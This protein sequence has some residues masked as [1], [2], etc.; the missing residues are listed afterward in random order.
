MELKKLEKLKKDLASASKEKNDALKRITI[1][2]VITET[3]AS[4]D[5]EPIL[6]GGAAVTFYTNGDYTTED[7]DFISP[8]GAE[9]SDLMAGLGFSKR[10]K[11]FINKKLSIYIEFPGEQLGPTERYDII[12]VS[13]ISVRI[14]SIED[15]VVDRL[16]AYKF[17]KSGID[18]VNA[19]R[20]LELGKADTERVEERAREEDVLDAL[21]YVQDVLEKATR[22]RL[23]PDEASKL[24]EKFTKR[25]RT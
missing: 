17:W 16:S 25:R 3:L 7:L 20:L 1:A 22:K 15:L 21:D 12:D 8:S 9:I 19:L 11:D 13:G 5:I 18:G 14:I 10:G 4:L 24:L 6:V 23:S 2:A